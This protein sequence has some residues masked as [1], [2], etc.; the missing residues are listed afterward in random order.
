MMNKKGDY[1]KTL[2]YFALGVAFFILMAWG[3]LS[4]VKDYND[5]NKCAPEK[6][7]EKSGGCPPG[8]TEI[9]KFKCEDKDNYMCCLTP[10]ES[11]KPNN[12]TQADTPESN[13]SAKP[14]AQTGNI[15]I[16]LGESAIPLSGSRTLKGGTEYTFTITADG[17]I[18]SCDI[19]VLDRETGTDVKSEPWITL[20]TEDCKTGTKINFDPRVA[21]LNNEYTLQVEGRNSSGTVLKTAILNLNVIIDPDMT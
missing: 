8:K 13:Q 12:S 15:N 21:Q 11:P 20:G 2:V 3:L 18:S 6:C 7:Y 5:Q 19:K 17:N 10:G 14:T 4:V 16:K 1:A 9:T